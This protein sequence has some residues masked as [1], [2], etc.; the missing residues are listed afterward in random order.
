MEGPL[1]SVI[2]PIYKVEPYLRRC[3]ESIIKQDYQNIEII[4]VDDGS[5]DRCGQICEEYAL[6]DTRIKVIHRPNGGL[7]AARNS[8]LEIC[9]GEYIGFVDSDDYI[10]PEMYSRLYKDILDYNTRLAFCHCDKFSGEK[11]PNG[12]ITLGRECRDKDYVMERSMSETKW[13]S[14]WAKLYH[15]SLFDGIRFP[16][17]RINEDYAI[18][19][20]IYDRCDKIVIDYNKLYHYFQREGSI[21]SMA[22]N[23]HSFDQVQ[24]ALEVLN[25]ITSH[26]PQHKEAAEFVLM[27]SVL[28][29]ISYADWNVFKEQISP[30]FAL[31]RKRYFSSIRNRY[32]LTKQKILLSLV[33]LHPWCFHVFRKYCLD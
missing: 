16:N 14:A 11:I 25:Y 2:V 27:S 15:R 31:C 33:A 23:I 22:V 9:S 8:G 32:I 18:M 1:I 21:S 26:N 28:R 5:P 17:N 30:L 24:N 6:Q 29:L 13:W 10:H 12:D 7:S 19:M 4:L 3:I 20:F